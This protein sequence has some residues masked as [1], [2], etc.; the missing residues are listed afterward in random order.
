MVQRVL[1]VA[2][3]LSHAAGPADVERARIRERI[4]DR[5]PCVGEPIG[6]QRNAMPG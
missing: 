1:E 4:L 5:A 6:P 3:G 2:R